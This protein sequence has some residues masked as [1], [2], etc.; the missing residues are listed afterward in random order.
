MKS[1]IFLSDEKIYQLIEEEKIIQLY[2]EDFFTRMKEK[3]GHKTFD[4][5]TPIKDGSSF[6]LLLRQ[7]R[8]NPLDFSAIL[9]YS[10]KE[11][12]SIFK[13]VRYNG[14]SH[15]HRNVL[16]KT[17]A[18][19]DF[20][21]HTATERYQLAGRKEESYAEVTERY[22]DLRGALRCLIKDCNVS[23]KTNPQVNLELE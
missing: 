1:T 7:N 5:S 2:F 16:E 21:I 10:P 14:K 13:L 19:Y 18:F 20:H 11:L 22:S 4:I 9:G 23:L 3:N 15:E 17:E 6:H 12:N 8:K